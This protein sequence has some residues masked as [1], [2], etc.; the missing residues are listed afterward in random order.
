MQNIQK[1]LK[2]Q[3]YGVSSN[4]AVK[5]CTW[6]KKSLL[7]KGFCYKQQFYGIKSHRCLQMTPIVN[8]CTQNCLFCWR[9]MDYVRGGK[10]DFDEPK[11]V[12][13]DSINEQRRLIAGFKGDERTNQEKFKEAWGPNQV[14]ISLLGEPTMYPY[15]DEL[16]KEYAKRKFTTFVVSNGTKPGVIK[17]I[18]P[19]QLYVTLPAPNERIYKELCKP[20]VNNGW[21]SIKQSLENLKEK[22]RSVVRMTMVKGWNMVEPE[23]YVDLIGNNAD[24]IEVKAYMF[25]GFSRQRMSMEN[26]PS[27]E[28]IVN[29]SKEL[30]KYSDYKII[31]EKKESRVVLLSRGKEPKITASQ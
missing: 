24:F 11:K 27:H 6:L 17:R 3:G 19:T 21:E 2:R 20:L 29:F 8:L 26:M 28:D 31:D 18:N 5:L 30:E 12:V 14:A 7:D 23:K 13:E 25:V 16:I 9:A 4:T 1:L 22:K 10:V 15:L